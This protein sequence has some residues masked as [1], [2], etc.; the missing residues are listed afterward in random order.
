MASV[1]P[2]CLEPGC[3]HSLALAELLHVP[4]GGNCAAP[5]PH[6]PELTI[7]GLTSFSVAFHFKGNRNPL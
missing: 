1:P 7:L 5:L 4:V 3:A 2:L 6:V